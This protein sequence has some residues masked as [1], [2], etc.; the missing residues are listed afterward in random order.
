MGPTT[1]VVGISM[2]W[3][4]SCSQDADRTAKLASRAGLKRTSPKG[5]QSVHVFGRGQSWALRTRNEACK[6]S[7]ARKTTHAELKLED[8][9]DLVHQD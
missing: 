2:E 3:S 9:T 4:T 1:S 7:T 5:N 8:A 6:A